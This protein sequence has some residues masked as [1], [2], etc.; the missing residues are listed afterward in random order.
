MSV[1]RVPTAHDASPET[2]LAAIRGF[3]G[4]L[5][6]DFDETLYLRNSTEDY[7]DCA[8]PGVAAA[9][10]M[11]LLDWI[12]PWQWTGG[13]L[14][15]DAWRVRVVTALLPWTARRWRRQAPQRVEQ[16][17]NAPL[18]GALRGHATR[19][20]IV[21]QGFHA[22]VTP[23]VAAFNL[24]E[25]GIVATHAAR[26]GDR[27]RGKLGLALDALGE[28]T[29]RRGLVI[30]DSSDDL[31]L[32][33]ACALPLRT[34]WPDARTHPALSEIYLPGRYLSRVKRPG[35]RYIVRG[36]LQEDFAF[37]LLASVALAGLPMLHAA[38]LLFLL[39]SFWAV[40]ECGYVDNDRIAARC[41]RD[42]RLSEAFHA[43]P[44][45]TPALEP[46][47][48]ALAS[49]ALAIVLLR[50]PALPAPAD[51]ALWS[52]V[53]LATH[54][55]FLLYNRF[56][57]R[58]RVWLYP[59]LQLARS[60]AFVVL[61]PVAAIGA[62]ALSAHVLAKWVPYYLYRNGERDWPEAPLPL[63]RLLF[64]VVLALLLA[65][66]QGAGALLNWTAAALLGWNLFRAR[67]G[68]LAAVAAARR[69]D[70]QQPPE[71]APPAPAGP[72]DSGPP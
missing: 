60:A 27:L 55:W 31:P 24:G 40:Y 43:A 21:T 70:R 16:F 10:L 46:W 4:P 11:K 35:E 53:L 3:D 69:I 20:I 5:L 47:I 41:E 61:V 52:G 64:F 14:T 39:L 6:L 68:I 58:T 63:I 2:A 8:R 19:P 9:A 62:A 17:G 67:A 28:D 66:T 59:G 48:W 13:E 26:F 38:G 25:S 42:P 36:V 34:V 30:T 18:L 72:P 33:D 12:R 71:P 51:L 15:R 44:V 7:I 50:W 45:P 1:E 37:W 32:L 56:D 57:K 29:V 23:L 65:L 22:I 49:G 54:G